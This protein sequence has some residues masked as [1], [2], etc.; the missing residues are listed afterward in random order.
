MGR[1]A[2]LKLDIE[3]YQK[4]KANSEFL[5]V[6]F[7]TSLCIACA[8]INS[9]IEDWVS[10]HQEVEYLFVSC[11]K[12]PDIAASESIFSAPAVLV[13]VE[14]KLTIRESGYFGMERIFQRL[15][16]YIEIVRGE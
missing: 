7:G 12:Y 3:K 11:E 1:E 13:F 5:I 2:T 15:E 14:G 16:Q 8:G 6:E 10:N 9:K 4:L